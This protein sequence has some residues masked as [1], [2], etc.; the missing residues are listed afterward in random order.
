MQSA[1]LI[2]SPEIVQN[3]LMDV[4]G[5]L[6]QAPHKTL[7]AVFWGHPCDVKLSIPDYQSEIAIHY[8]SLLRGKSVRSFAARTN[9]PCNFDHFGVEIRFHRPSEI[10][11]HDQELSLDETLRR[12]VQ[13]FGPTILKNAFLPAAIRQKAQR[14]I[15]PHLQFH[16]DRASNQPTQ[17]SLFSRDP[18]DEV[19]KEPRLSSTVF[20]ANVVGILQ[21]NLEGNSSKDPNVLQAI[22]KI[23]GSENAQ[24]QIGKIMLEQAWNEPAGTGEISILDNRTVLHASYYR[25]RVTKGYPIG[26]RYLR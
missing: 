19:Q 16:Y 18:F 4:L 13:R 11:V 9:V 1:P 17:Y 7:T 21:S 15:F 24:A 3:S 8:A 23:F 22:Y 5:N 6:E 25:D 20:I 14:N 2:K 12:I 10:V 26:V